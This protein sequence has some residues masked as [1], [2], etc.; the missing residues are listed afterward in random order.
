[1][2]YVG[3]GLSIGQYLAGA[4]P[5]IISDASGILAKSGIPEIVVTSADSMHPSQLAALV[6]TKT[7]YYCHHADGGFVE[8]GGSGTGVSQWTD[9]VT[10]GTKHATATGAA[11]PTATS[12]GG[13]GGNGYCLSF[14]GTSNGLNIAQSITPGTTPFFRRTLARVTS[15]FTTGGQLTCGSSTNRLGVRVTTGPVASAGNGTNGSSISISTGIWYLFDEYFSNS[16]NDFLRIGTS[17]TVTGTNLGNT[18]ASSLG[19]GARSDAIAAWLKH[20]TVWSFGCNGLPTNSE[21]NAQ[22]SW[23]NSWYGPSNIQVPNYP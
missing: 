20:D 3:L 13:P 9:L 7:V 22:A 8:S 14:N 18:V 6:T 17:T 15:G 21:L 4:Y 23:L 12:S 5:V 11:K 10:S 1:M 16:T 2:T 19:I